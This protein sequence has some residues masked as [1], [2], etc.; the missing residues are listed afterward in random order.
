MVTWSDSYLP[1]CWTGW[2]L[3]LNGSLRNK[4]IFT[5]S[6]YFLQPSNFKLQ[7]NIFLI[8]FPLLFKQN[9]KCFIPTK[10]ESSPHFLNVW[11]GFKIQKDIW[12]F[13]IK[14]TTTI[15]KFVEI[16]SS[17]PIP[18]IKWNL[19]SATNQIGYYCNVSFHHNSFLQHI[20]TK[21]LKISWLHRYIYIY[22]LHI[23]S[24]Q[25]EKNCFIFFKNTCRQNLDRYEALL[26]S[27]GSVWQ[28]YFP[29][30][31]FR[32][33]FSSFIFN[34]GGTALTHKRKHC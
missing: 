33:N 26:K 3:S 18:V 30:F 6:I 32:N 17:S 7:N 19:T 12:G 4:I 16:K 24:S 1:L 11:V 9:S 29:S 21:P 2:R 14:K 31:F 34:A 22:S 15:D 10:F 25:N 20:L 13:L 5:K 8:M 28:I 27:F 23:Y